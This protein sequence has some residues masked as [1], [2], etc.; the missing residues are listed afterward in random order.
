MKLNPLGV[1]QP[2][3]LNLWPEIFLGFRKV[4][5]VFYADKIP[6]QIQVLQNQVY[7]I[8]DYFV[9]KDQIAKERKE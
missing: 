2:V 4:P 8:E 9:Q 3:S 7:Y 6:I 5:E 1:W